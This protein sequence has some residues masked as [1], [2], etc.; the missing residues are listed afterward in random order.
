MAGL[1]AVSSII[2][3]LGTVAEAF[4]VL[5]DIPN[6]PAVIYELDN[7]L[8]S[9]RS[10]IQTIVDHHHLHTEAITKELVRA[11]ESLHE[12]VIIL[13]KCADIDRQRRSKPIQGMRW[14]FKDKEKATSLRNRLHNHVSTLGLLLSKEEM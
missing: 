4:R 10:S 9:F 11:N 13:E 7:Q 3:V 5:R 2:P 1:S 6:A 14:T 12:A 8:Q